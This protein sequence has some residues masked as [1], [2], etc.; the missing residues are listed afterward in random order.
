[1]FI[2]R[3]DGEARECNSRSKRMLQAMMWIKEG[4]SND[5]AYTRNAQLVFVSYV[6]I[7]DCYLQIIDYLG[8]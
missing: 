5:H 6:Y 3:P 7:L 2:D 1:M 4:W 8:S